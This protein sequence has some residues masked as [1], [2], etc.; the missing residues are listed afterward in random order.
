MA[1][2][3]DSRLFPNRGACDEGGKDSSS[4][5]FRGGC[6]TGTPGSGKKLSILAGV[7]GQRS[8]VRIGYRKRGLRALSVD[9]VF[10]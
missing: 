4:I 8:R 6:D 3:R 7:E 10:P 2:G 1:I 9:R 5:L